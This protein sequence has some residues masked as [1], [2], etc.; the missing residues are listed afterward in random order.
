MA[1]AGV[2]H[3][4]H[5]R[6]GSLFARVVPRDPLEALHRRVDRALTSVGLAPE[7]RAYFP[8]VTLARARTG[9]E[10]PQRWIEANAGLSVE[11]TPFRRMI[12]YESHLGREGASYEA[13]EAYRL[14]VAGGME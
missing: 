3:F 9:A 8:H 6:H 5:G 10:P 4:D 11:P 14:P 2:G 1:L 13:I 7:R 12:L